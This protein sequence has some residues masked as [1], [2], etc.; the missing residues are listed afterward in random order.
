MDIATLLRIINL[1]AARNHD[2][3]FTLMAFT[4]HFR[5]AYGTPGTTSEEGRRRIERVPYFTSLTE[6][7]VNM[8]IKKPVF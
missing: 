8:I 3:H 7:L 6:S 2:G 1:E 4:T 5:S